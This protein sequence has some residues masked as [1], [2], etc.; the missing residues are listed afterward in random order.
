[1]SVSCMATVKNE[2]GIHARPSAMIAKESLKYNSEINIIYEDRIANA[3]DVLQ[4]IMLELF[5]GI[6]VEITAK[7][8]DENEAMAA[9][10]NLIENQFIFD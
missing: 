9:I 5:Q 1:M 2:R 6:T 8:D 3:K 4:L 7:G 10:K